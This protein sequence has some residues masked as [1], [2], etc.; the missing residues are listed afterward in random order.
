MRQA[1]S[2]GMALSY[3]PTK[4]YV[5]RYTWVDQS[6]K[7]MTLGFSSSSLISDSSSMGSLLEDSL[8]L[9]FPLLSCAH[10]LSLSNCFNYIFNLTNPVIQILFIHLHM[11]VNFL[12]KL[13]NSICYYD[14]MQS[15]PFLHIY[16]VHKDEKMKLYKPFFFLQ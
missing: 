8:P 7:N 13:R 4:N 16:S 6:V 9:P 14:N 12:Q 10:A 11:H 2:Q 1:C 15:C 5:F 3:Y